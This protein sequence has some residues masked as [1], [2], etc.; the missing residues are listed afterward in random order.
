MC[1]LTY[2]PL[3][4]E[5][6]IITTNRDES[7]VRGHVTFPAYHHL[8]SKNIIFPKDPLA[9]GSWIATTDNGISA[10]LLNGANKP[11]E[12][13][14]PYRM[15]RGLV[16]LEA[17]ECIKPDEFFK[18]F[19]FTDIEPFTM[20]VFFHDP[21]LKILEFKWDG[22]EKYLKKFD[23]S[24]P[25]IWASAQLYT[26]EAIADRKKWFKMWLAENKDYTIESIREFHK[27]GGSG[28]RG[29]DLVMDRGE[30]KTVSISHIC[31]RLGTIEI[32]H[33]N[34]LEHTLQELI[35]SQHVNQEFSHQVL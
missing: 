12:Y 11:H 35:L 30:V 24:Q 16:L 15:S 27:Y 25:H 20:V 29:N 17:I 32:G 5:Q 33:E 23:S 18:N 7:P 3:K 9:G 19:D 1:T 4:N 13:K 34:L 21:E 10:C 28:D 2:L 31:S 14:P 22:V 6:F 26:K 8:E